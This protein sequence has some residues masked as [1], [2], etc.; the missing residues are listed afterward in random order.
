MLCTLKAEAFSK[1]YQTYKMMLFEKKVKHLLAV[2]YFYK[3][4]EISM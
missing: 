1:P 3:R 2:N 4:L